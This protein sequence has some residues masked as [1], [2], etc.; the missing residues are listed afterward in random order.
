MNGQTV[1]NPTPDRVEQAPATLAGL[2]GRWTSN[3]SA[4]VP[5]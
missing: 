1:I 3:V 5:R 2:A 4:D